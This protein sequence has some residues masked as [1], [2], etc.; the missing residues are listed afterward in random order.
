MANSTIP[1]LLWVNARTGENGEADAFVL[2]TLL[3]LFFLLGIGLVSGCI[4][5]RRAHRPSPHRR[6]L[7]DLEAQ[8]GVPGDDLLSA[9]EGKPGAAWEKD[10]DW[11]KK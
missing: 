9:E 6:L 7:M 3:I 1:F 10:A 5:W 11:W 8:G 4:L 2:S